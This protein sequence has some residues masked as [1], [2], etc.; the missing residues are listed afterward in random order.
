MAELRFGLATLAAAYR[1][2]LVAGPPGSTSARL[3][4]ALARIDDA[5]LALIRYPNET[6]LLQALIARLPAAPRA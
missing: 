1:D 6:L 5:G 2:A 3:V 4:D